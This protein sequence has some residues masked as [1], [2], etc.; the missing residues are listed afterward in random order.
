[1]SDTVESGDDVVEVT[2]EEEQVELVVQNDALPV[3]SPKKRQRSLDVSGVEEVD[4]ETLHFRKRAQQKHKHL[5][6]LAKEY[7]IHCGKNEPVSSFLSRLESLPIT[8]GGCIKED[9]IVDS[10]E[11]DS[12]LEEDSDSSDDASESENDGSSPSES[13]RRRNQPK[14]SWREKLQREV[15]LLRSS[16]PTYTIPSSDDEEQEPS[17]RPRRGGKYRL[18]R[19]I[20][21][22]VTNL[23][24]AE[25]LRRRSI[26]ND[27]DSHLATPAATEP[28]VPADEW[29]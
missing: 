16:A 28:W 12:S 3:K 1:M 11:V 29:Q 8:S 23:E 17:A 27:F 10:D 5:L 18:R 2:S 26:D 20:Y 19:N 22:P 7:G 13:T 9:Y 21:K 15:E 4:D 14:K 6:A 24:F 25:Q